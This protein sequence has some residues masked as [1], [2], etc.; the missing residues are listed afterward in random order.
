[1]NKTVESKE[2]KIRKNGKIK[3]DFER[4]SWF[5]RFRIK[6]LSLF[7]L[8]KFVWYIFR[9][10]LMIGISYVIIFPF[11]TKIAGSFMSPDDFVDVSVKLIP[12]YPTLDT[13]KAI[14]SENRYY[15]ALLNTFI[16]SFLSAVIQM[17][18][19]TLV[20][21]G[22]SKFKFKGNK[23]VFFCVIFTM[24]IPHDTLMFSMFIQFR[25]FDIFGIYGYLH[26]LLDLPSKYPYFNLIDTYWPLAILS[27]G[28]LALKNGLYIFMM[29]QFF[30]GVPDEL[31]EA[32]YVDGSGVFK[33]FIRIILPLSIPMMITI[34]LF[35]FSWQWTD[36]FYTTK[37]FTKQGLYL[38]PH[39]VEVPR[40]LED[41]N[42][43]ARSLYQSAILNTC[44]L[45]IIL[46]LIIMYS[47]CQKFLVQ[48]IER[49]GIVG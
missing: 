4:T 36:T 20:G 2:K 1:M 25:Y 19:C 33:T 9:L 13:Y 18:V 28:G 49:S 10:A 41:A 21:Y 8:K 11:I 30:K 48:G 22:P 47:F 23:I 37:F 29:R 45:M 6:Y 27:I 14:I 31:E 46:P 7:F 38:L 32:A 17:F 15:E 26:E 24:I 12:K 44:G 43:A 5:E 34:F 39:I 35:A 40:S 16:L 3:V 42:F